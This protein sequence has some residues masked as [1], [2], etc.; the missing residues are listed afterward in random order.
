MWYQYQHN[1]LTVISVEPAPGMNESSGHQ[2]KKMKVQKAWLVCVLVWLA[3]DASAYAARCTCVTCGGVFVPMC[4]AVRSVL[5]TNSKTTMVI[6]MDRSLGL[7]T[8]TLL[9]LWLHFRGQEDVS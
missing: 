9:Q 2:L 4:S 3:V 8:A 5:Q 7:N 1:S 6:K